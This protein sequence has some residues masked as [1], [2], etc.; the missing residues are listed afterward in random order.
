[1]RPGIERCRIKSGPYPIPKQGPDVARVAL[2][3]GGARGIGADISRRLAADGFTVVINYA[4]SVAAA[5]ALVAEIEFRGGTAGAVQADVGDTR[6]VQRMFARTTERFG[7]PVALVN[8]A[9]LNFSGSAR[10]QSP[11]DWDRVISVNLSGAYYCT[12]A[13]LPGM[14]EQGWGRIV[15]F[16]S[17]A[18]GR[19]PVPTLSA[20]AA[21]KAGLAGMTC[22]M[23]KEVARR[24]ITV[25]T[26]VPG[27]VLT[28][29]ISE[30]GADT[31]AAMDRLWPKIPAGAVAS[32]VSFLLSDGAQYVSGEEIGVWLGG[33]LPSL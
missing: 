3:T 29:M 30:R 32:M 9:G 15:F 27:Y 14:Y 6:A 4:T 21:A 28:E 10:N 11:E 20:Y 5:E 22:V 8:N 23:A 25:N 19:Q 12:H 31:V 7:A 24:G 17:A 1:M 2:V 13:A 33:P 26:V 16:G 18:A